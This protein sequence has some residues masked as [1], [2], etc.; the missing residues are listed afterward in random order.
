M[1]RL[2]NG[3]KTVFS[4]DDVEKTGYCTQKNEVGPYDPVIPP[5]RIYSKELKAGR[6][7]KKKKGSTIGEEEE[8]INF[9]IILYHFLIVFH[10]PFTTLNLKK[11]R[12]QPRN[13]E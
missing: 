12:S 2:V 4:T 6:L 11:N 3:E 9:N 8:D 1:L 13:K 10:M 7:K 5:L